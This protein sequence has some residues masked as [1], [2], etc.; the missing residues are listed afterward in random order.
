[1]CGAVVARDVCWPGQS[2]TFF[3]IISTPR[4]VGHG[5]C[6]AG[7]AHGSRASAAKNGLGPCWPLCRRSVSMRL[8]VSSR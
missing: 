4:L 7:A 3:D 8:E 2:I 1:M 6:S 5:L